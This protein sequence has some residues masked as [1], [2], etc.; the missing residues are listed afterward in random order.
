MKLISVITPVFNEAENVAGCAEALRIV[1]T[2]KL[3]SYEYEHIF[4]DNASTDLTLQ[5]LRQLAIEDHRIKII[6]NSRNVGPFRNIWNAMKSASGDAVIPM[7]PA[8][9]QDPAEIIPEFVDCW[10][11]GN[12]VVFG[13]RM[14]RD[15]SIF[16]R[17]ARF[18]YY[19][20]ISKF[21]TST[22]PPNCGEFLL[23]DRRVIDSVL[24]VDDQYP[25]IRGLIAQTN[26]KNKII[27]YDW[28]KRQK[29]KSKNNFFDL[30]D[31]AMNGFVATSRIAA[32]C[33]LLLGFLLSFLG[34][35]YAVTT[36]ALTIFGNGNTPTGIPTIIAGIFL[37]GG[38]Q[39]FFLGL[40]GEY[41]LSIHNQIRRTPSIFEIERVN[42]DA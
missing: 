31:Q 9:L 3:P 41:V 4:A 16:M 20:I 38:F 36:V 25:Y 5:K 1:M 34:V 30:V 2:T 21:A 39:L 22:I 27:S 32:R 33:S 19:R 40:I 37:L 8:D 29:G 7:L 24:A 13:K 23:A 15:E 28:M 18:H 14:N 42:F 17:A 11:Q 12:L 35:A 26:V 10:S 6:V